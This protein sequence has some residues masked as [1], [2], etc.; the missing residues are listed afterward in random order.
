MA[1]ASSTAAFHREE[2]RSKGGRG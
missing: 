1:T 2:K